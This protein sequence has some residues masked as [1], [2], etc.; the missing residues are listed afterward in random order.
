MLEVWPSLVVC[1]W[2]WKIIFI[3]VVINVNNNNKLLGKG[4][5][6][7]GHWLLLQFKFLCEL[8]RANTDIH[9]RLKNESKLKKEMVDPL[10][11]SPPSNNNFGFVYIS[12]KTARGV[13]PAH[14]RAFFSIAASQRASERA[15]ERNAHETCF[16]RGCVRIG[17][18]RSHA[19]CA[20]WGAVQR[21]SR[22]IIPSRRRL[23][24]LPFLLPFRL[25]LDDSYHNHYGR[26]VSECLCK[27]EQL[28]EN[29][30]GGVWTPHWRA[31]SWSIF[32]ECP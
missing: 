16:L 25:W 31:E 5:G 24:L 7:I 6:C 11:W 13:S 17:R 23:L 4:F 1:C 21:Q 27:L 26:N 22:R 8:N 30:A 19:R 9:R 12:A 32:M 14:L 15:A 18:R 3:W 2:A 29:A 20:T 28:K 10:K